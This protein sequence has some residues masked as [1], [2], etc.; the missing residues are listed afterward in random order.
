M[1]KKG[2]YD[3]LT[4]LLLNLYHLIEVLRMELI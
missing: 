2:S 3:H 4:L 1:E